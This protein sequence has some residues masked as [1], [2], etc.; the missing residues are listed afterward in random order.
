MII[1]ATVPI[2]SVWI[3]SS[4]FPLGWRG[5]PPCLILM[6]TG[7]NG[8]PSFSTTDVLESENPITTA[9]YYNIT[10]IVIKGIMV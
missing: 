2:D 7:K 4:K 5:K 9:A 3:V 6:Q 8:A 1:I 10:E